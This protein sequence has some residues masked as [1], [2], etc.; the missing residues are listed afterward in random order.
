MKA[1]I[2][3]NT[4]DG[5]KTIN[6]NCGS[7]SDARIYLANF[8]SDSYFGHTEDGQFAIVNGFDFSELEEEDA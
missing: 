7:Q 3:I 4:K 5:V 2:K 8:K 1:I 6:K